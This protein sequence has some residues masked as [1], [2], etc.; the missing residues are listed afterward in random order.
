MHHI[1]YRNTYTK[2]TRYILTEA[3]IHYNNKNMRTVALWDTGAYRSHIT[4]DVINAF[5]CEVIGDDT[6]YCHSGLYTATK[7]K[8]DIEFPIGYT[9][10]NVTVASTAN[11][12]YKDYDIG[13]LIG[14][15]I[16][17][18]GDF[19]F[20]CSGENMV[21]TFRLPYDGNED[22]LIETELF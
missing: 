1:T 19:H 11:I 17:R 18:L 14:M 10:K 20:E 5:D 22:K 2:G 9:I 21:F 12:T 8:I 15:D 3:I 16:I 7:H 4:E 6:S 13:L